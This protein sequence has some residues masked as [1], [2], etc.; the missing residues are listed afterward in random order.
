MAAW[1]SEELDRIGAAE[2][3]EITSLR[4]DGTPSRAT[5]IWVVRIGDDLY[6]RSVNGRASR[7]FQGALERREGKIAAGGIE[8][9]VTFIEVG[10]EL[11]TAL[12]AAYRAKYRR[13]AKSIVDSVL[14]PHAQ[15]AT[16]KFNPRP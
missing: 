8:R 13:Y 5:T 4:Q 12:D 9:D 15:S 14:T 7:W 10:R 11:D 16:I 1:T 3:L 6:A 2:E